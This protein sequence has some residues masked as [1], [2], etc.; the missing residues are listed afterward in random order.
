MN[1]DENS[2]TITFNVESRS[3]YHI[4]KENLPDKR[5]FNQVSRPSELDHHLAFTCISECLVARVYSEVFSRALGYVKCYGKQSALNNCHIYFFKKSKSLHCLPIILFPGINW[6]EPAASFNTV[7][8]A[9]IL[10]FILYST[11]L[12]C[13]V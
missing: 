5:K 9:L 10:L 11:M 4:R 6:Q 8:T 7:I 3:V 13:M 2:Y 12:Y 1:A